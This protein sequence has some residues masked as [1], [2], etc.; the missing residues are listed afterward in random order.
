MGWLDRNRN[1]VFSVLLIIIAIGIAVL[2]LQRRDGPQPLEIHFDGPSAEIKVQ[3]DGAVQNPGVYPLS[4][5]SRI[6][7]ALAAAGSATD[8]ANLAAINLAQRLDDEDKLVI[9]RRGETVNAVTSPG[10]RI[11]INSASAAELDSLPGIGEVYSQRIIESRQSMGRFSTID[12]LAAR[13]VIPN[14]T[15]EKIKNLITAG[16]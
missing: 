16:P 8:D 4:E 10:D 13:Q 6:E 15:Y 2:F 3:V 7:D 5:G 12:E 9:P 11:D 1:S 14:S